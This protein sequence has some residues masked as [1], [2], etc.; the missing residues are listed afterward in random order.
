M[1][2]EVRKTLMEVEMADSQESLITPGQQVGRESQ[3]SLITPGQRT[4]EKTWRKWRRGVK[5]VENIQMSNKED[6]SGEKNSSIERSVCV[7]AELERKLEAHGLTY[8]GL[9]N[10]KM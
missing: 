4:P 6:E 8:A 2:D 9:T 7:P 1:A 5:S 10:A 3:D